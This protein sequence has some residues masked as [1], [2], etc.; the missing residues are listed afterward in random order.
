[1]SPG[2][3]VQRSLP[4]AHT[5]AEL[6]LHA[7]A[8]IEEVTRRVAGA[9]NGEPARGDWPTVP[10]LDSPLWTGIK[11]DIAGAGSILDSLLAATPHARLN[12][13]ARRVG[14]ELPPDPISYETM[15]H[16][17]AQHNAYHGGQISMLKRALRH[18]S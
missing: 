8:W 11:G 14:G 1:V 16:G 9:D 5:I 13:L 6:A 10:E 18:P 4:G 12:E 7:L 2:E 3:A 15:L 17:L